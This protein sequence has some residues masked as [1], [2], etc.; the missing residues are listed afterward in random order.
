MENILKWEKRLGLRLYRC[1]VRILRWYQ[2]ACA[3][4]LAKSGHGVALPSL[5]GT[6]PYVAPLYSRQCHVPLACDEREI[7]VL[8]G[9]PQASSGI[10]CLLSV[11]TF[12]PRS[13]HNLC[14]LRGGIIISQIPLL[15]PI[16][17]SR[18]RKVCVPHRYGR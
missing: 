5:D 17:V 3:R 10:L 12:P 15:S 14:S 2:P 7:G 13:L 4:I 9:A 6:S 1:S 11:Y 18:Y 16:V 8:V